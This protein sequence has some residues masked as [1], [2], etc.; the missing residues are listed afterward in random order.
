MTAGGALPK[1][2][3]TDGQGGA[4]KITSAARFSTIVGPASA[5]ASAEA[6][7]ECR[8]AA[9]IAHELSAIPAVLAETSCCDETEWKCAAAIVCPSIRMMAASTAAL[10]IICMRGRM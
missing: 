10:R 8:C 3:L 2:L 6:A 5:V 1:Q 7:G 9:Q 4:R